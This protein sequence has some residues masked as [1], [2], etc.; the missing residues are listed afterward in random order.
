ML[1]GKNSKVQYA[2]QDA[3]RKEPRLTMQEQCS[4]ADEGTQEKQKADQQNSSLPRKNMHKN[5]AIDPKK[6]VTEFL[7]GLYHGDS[8][9]NVH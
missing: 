3:G 5:L 7:F 9:Y 2:R 1:Q 4:M 8:T 6:F